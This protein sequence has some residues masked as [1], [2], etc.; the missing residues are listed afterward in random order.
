MYCSKCSNHPVDTYVYVPYEEARPIMDEFG[1][2]QLAVNAERPP[3]PDPTEINDVM[4]QY[5]GDL[6]KF[7][8]C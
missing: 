6:F 3:E 5:F 4:V 7:G 2:A 8:V 1:Y